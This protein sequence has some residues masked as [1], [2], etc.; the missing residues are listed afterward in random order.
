MY[1]FLQRNTCIHM[2]LCLERNTCIHGY[3]LAFVQGYM[4]IHMFQE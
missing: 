4:Y 1:M 3:L 2:Y